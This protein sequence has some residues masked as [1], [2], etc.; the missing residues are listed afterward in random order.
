MSGPVEEKNLIGF[1]FRQR[2]EAANRDIRRLDVAE[3][4]ELMLR[5]YEVGPHQFGRRKQEDTLILS[6]Q[7]FLF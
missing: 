6:I 7:P 3:G 1:N 5:F 4:I 2:V